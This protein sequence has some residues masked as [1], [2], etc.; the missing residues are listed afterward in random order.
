MQ[1]STAATHNNPLLSE[2]VGSM[3]NFFDRVE[4]VRLKQKTLLC[5]GLDPDP[6][7]IPQILQNDPDPMLSFNREIMDATSDLVCC[8]KPQIA[9]YAAA[10]AE[11]TLQKTIEYAHDKG[12]PVLLDFKRGD[13]GS[14]AEMYAHEGFERYGADAVTINPYMG[15]DSMEPFLD[16]ADKG[17]FILCRTSNPGGSDL[18]NL[19]LE[20]GKRLYEHVA[21]LAVTQWNENKNIGLVVG[22]TRPEEIASIRAIVGD[23][24]FLLPGVGAQGA[25]V[26]IMMEHASGGSMI[27]NSARAVLYASNQSDFAAKAR[28][29]AL[30]TRDQIR[31]FQI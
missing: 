15:F 10:G 12:I 7:R 9:Y 18:Q 5:V 13:I 23:M 22:A 29:V 3:S 14:T 28:Q 1:Q 8:Y 19:V 31:Q 16:Y 2:E 25:D 24:N 17:I 26:K 21:E 27:I 6:A 11:S 4:D 30:D 20:S